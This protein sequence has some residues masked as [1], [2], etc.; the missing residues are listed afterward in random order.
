MM[1]EN[2]IEYLD[3]SFLAVIDEIASR[4]LATEY[5][6]MFYTILFPAE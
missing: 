2:D 4:D 3:S 5:I 1:M 6:L